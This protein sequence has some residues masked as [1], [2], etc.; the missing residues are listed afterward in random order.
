MRLW[1]RRGNVN[2][3]A[4]DETGAAERG[5]PAPGQDP[6][7]GSAAHVTAIVWRHQNG[8]KWRAIPADLG[9]WWRAAQ[10]FIR[11]ALRCVRAAAAPCWTCFT[12]KALWAEAAQN[13]RVI[14]DKVSMRVSTPSPPTRAS[15]RCPHGPRMG[16][17]CPD[18]DQQ[19]PTPATIRWRADPSA[20]RLGSFHTRRRGAAALRQ[21]KNAKDQE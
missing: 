16:E 3:R 2:E 12:S 18:V 20:R 6:A 11:C 21:N 14:T 19:T 17:L 4:M 10:T 7:S 1:M 8:A 15:R 13:A 5:V 9:P